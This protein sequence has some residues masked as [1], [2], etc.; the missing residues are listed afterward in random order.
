MKSLRRPERYVIWLAAGQ[1]AEVNN[2]KNTN[3]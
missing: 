3:S 1:H 2:N